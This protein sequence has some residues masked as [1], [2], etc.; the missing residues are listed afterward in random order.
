MESSSPPAV[1]EAAAPEPKKKRRLTQEEIEYAMAMERRPPFRPPGLD[2]FARLSA[3]G[4]AVLDLLAS[5]AEHVEELQDDRM[6]YKE[7]VIREFAAK[8]YVEVT[9]YEDDEEEEEEK[10]WHRDMIFDEEEEEEEKE[11]DDE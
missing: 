4:Q 9:D 2:L 3:R 7:R 5:A 1:V 6:A 8:G 10:E 11:K